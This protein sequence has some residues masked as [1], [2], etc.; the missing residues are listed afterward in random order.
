MKL[1]RRTLFAAGASL[2]AIA[3]CPTV[4]ASRQAEE[5]LADTVRT[6]LSAAIFGD[7]P[8][9]LETLA[10]AERRR[11]VAWRAGTDARLRTRVP[12]DALRQEFLA[13]AWY[14]CRRAGLDTALVLGLVEQESGFR[15]YAI[16]AV[17]ARGY[18]QVMPFWSRS[19]G[20]GNPSDLFHAQTNMRF[21]CAILRSYL[22]KER[23]DLFM[24][25]GRY[26]GSRGQ[27]K[28]PQSV[29]ALSRR[30]T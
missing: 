9:Q 8:P 24:A 30:W 6:A 13:C 12:D 16:S 27:A 22:E 4:R 1:T 5:P 23:G 17:G 29:L 28:Y 25:L 18:M 19:I 21:G 7:G 26:N 2:A 14:E 11:F 10:E 3:S 20:D 15:K